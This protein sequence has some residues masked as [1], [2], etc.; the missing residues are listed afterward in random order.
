MNSFRTVLVLAVLWTGAADAGEPVPPIEPA[1]KAKW[2]E[3]LS[4]SVDVAVNGKYM[5]RGIVIVNEA[6]H[7]P[8]VCLGY[9][10]LTLCWWANQE[11]TN[12][13]NHANDFTE[14]DY[15]LDYTWRWGKA[16]LM[17]GYVNYRFPNTAIPE[18]SE[19]YGHVALDVPLSPKLK[20]Y[21]EIDEV[22]GTYVNLSVGHR[23]EN[24]LR[25]QRGPTVSVGLD[26]A[27][28]W[29]S[30]KHNQANYGFEGSAVSDAILS[31][32]LPVQLSKHWTLTPAIYYSM[33]LDNRIR[34][35]MEKDDNLWGGVTLSVSF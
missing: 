27:V 17:V 2:R 35:A 4:L 11:L 5:W 26:A 34:R 8:Q 18:N 10:G 30:R 25:A 14:M 28:G 24:V 12:A 29:G 31:L 22:W 19:L 21:R 1:A 23:F 33:L 20:V 7:Q 9:R 13:T 32:S 16:E 6:V 3:D 15:S